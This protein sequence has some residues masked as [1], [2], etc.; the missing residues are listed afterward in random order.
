MLTM[1]HP[2]KV[3]QRLNLLMAEFNFIVDIFDFKNSDPK[4]AN[5]VQ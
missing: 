3:M 1:K 4:Y 5:M 2:E